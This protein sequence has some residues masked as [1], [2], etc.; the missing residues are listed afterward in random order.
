MQT[1]RCLGAVGIFNRERQICE[2]SFIVLIG[3]EG[4][5]AAV[6][7]KLELWIPNPFQVRE[8][9]KTQISL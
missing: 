6:K 2:N 8:N 5:K 4:E 1:K 9:Q 3:L 7:A